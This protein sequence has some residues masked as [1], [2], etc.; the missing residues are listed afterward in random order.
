MCDSPKSDSKLDSLIKIALA[1]FP[2]SRVL[3]EEEAGPMR[4]TKKNTEKSI[5][6]DARETCI[7]ITQT[8]LPFSDSVGDLS[9]ATRHREKATERSSILKGKGGNR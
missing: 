8:S 9:G 5:S 1:V 6:V 7:L 2:G 3:T 4:F